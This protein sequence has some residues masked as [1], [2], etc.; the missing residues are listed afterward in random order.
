MIIITEAFINLEREKQVRILNAAYKEFSEQGFEKASTNRIVKEAGIGKGMLFYYFNNKKDLYFYLIEKGG[1]YVIEEYFNQ[2]DESQRDFIEKYK[3]IAM[4][5]MKAYQENPYV[6]TF[7][8]SIY[9]NHDVD[10]SDHLVQMLNEIRSKAFMKLFKNIDTTLFREDVPPETVIKLIRWT[11][12]GY[13]KELVAGYQ[14]KKLTEIDM[15]PY[16]DE[17]YQ[18]LDYLKKIYYK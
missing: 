2:I 17:F 9:I 10:L 18:Y 12:D 6:F 4:L 1:E 11:L 3:E 15:G 13:E 16:W 7:L 5:K 14:G 8:G